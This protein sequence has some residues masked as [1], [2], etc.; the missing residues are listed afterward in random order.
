MKEIKYLIMFL[1]YIFPFSV[2]LLVSTQA[3]SNYNVITDLVFTFVQPP[4]L[5]II[6]VAVTV[7]HVTTAKKLTV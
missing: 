6:V 1:W 4:Q 5:N 2:F 3:A 7:L